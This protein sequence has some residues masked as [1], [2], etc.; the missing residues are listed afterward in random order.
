MASKIRKNDTVK[1]IA[2]KDRGKTGR[3]VRFKREE[4]RVVVEGLNMVKKAIRPKGQKQKGG[5]TTVE[6]PIPVSNV[7]VVCKKCGPTRVG[8]VFQEDRK[9][10]ICK[11]CR[12]PLA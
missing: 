1:V 12:E 9:I 6:A 3:V 7:M 11:K 10:R 5:I 8:F 4:N 2:G